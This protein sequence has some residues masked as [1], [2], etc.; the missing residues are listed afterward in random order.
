MTRLEIPTHTFHEAFANTLEE[1]ELLEDWNETVCDAGIS[2]AE[3]TGMF[4]AFL[5]LDRGDGRTLQADLK[6]PQLRSAVRTACRTEARRVAG[7]VRSP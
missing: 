7:A 2:Q 1:A 5:G 4:D 3:S 6:D